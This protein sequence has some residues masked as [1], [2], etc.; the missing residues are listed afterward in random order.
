MENISFWFSLT[1]KIVLGIHQTTSTM[2]L[3]TPDHFPESSL[4][5]YPTCTDY[6]LYHFHRQELGTPGNFRNYRHQGK[7]KWGP[8]PGRETMHRNM[9]H[10]RCVKAHVKMCV[11]VCVCAYLHPRPEEKVL[12][13]SPGWPT[14]CAGIAEFTQLQQLTLMNKKSKP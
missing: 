9:K 5:Q 11:C 6:I 8:A 3:L 14:T 7:R 2:R 13:S 1:Q 12:Q 10:I 4:S